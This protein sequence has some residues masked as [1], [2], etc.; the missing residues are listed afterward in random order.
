MPTSSSSRPSRVRESPARSTNRTVWSCISKACK[1]V[2]R[3]AK[4]DPSEVKGIGFDATCSLAVA[5]M[6]GRPMSVSPGQW[7]VGDE[8]HNIILWADHRAVE[9]AATINASGSHVLKYVGGTMSLEM[10]L[11]KVRAISG[12]R[13]TVR[14][15][16]SRSTCRT[17]CSSKA[18]SSTCPM[19]VSHAG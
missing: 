1:D 18:S 13:L 10:E 6:N 7:G 12:A 14:S 17:S 3:E 4:I 2:V 19:S 15:S 11:P 5:D 8:H 9:E 16:G